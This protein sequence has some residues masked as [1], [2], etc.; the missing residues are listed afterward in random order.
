MRPRWP[1][2]ASGTEPP[3]RSR[4]PDHNSRRRPRLRAS[5]G[6]LQEWLRHHLSGH[7]VSRW[8]EGGDDPNALAVLGAVT[9]PSARAAGAG[10]ASSPVGVIGPLSFGADPTRQMTVAAELTIRPEGR[11]AIDI[12]RSNDYGH[13]VETE[14]MEEFWMAPERTDGGEVA[15]ECAR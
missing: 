15:A 13:I 12:R 7:R 3:R 10:A 11:V 5:I 14:V 9:A 2:S 1:P 6:E 4:H 8:T